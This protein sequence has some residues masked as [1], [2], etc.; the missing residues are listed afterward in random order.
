MPF[1]EIQALKD[2]LNA[3][4]RDAV[5]A[6]KEKLSSLIA[7]SEWDSTETFFREYSE[8]F[9]GETSVLGI[10]ASDFRSFVDA[11]M[12][13]EEFED[14]MTLNRLQSYFWFQNVEDTEYKKG[15]IA[16]KL[17]VFG[18]HMV[19]LINLQDARSCYRRAN[20]REDAAR[21]QRMLSQEVRQFELGPPTTIPDNSSIAAQINGMITRALEEWQSEDAGAKMSAL[22]ADF[23]GIR[24]TPYDPNQSR[25]SDIFSSGL[26]EELGVI[27]TIGIST[28]DGRVDTGRMASTPER[29]HYESTDVM[30]R[31]FLRAFVD[32]VKA[33]LKI[34]EGEFRVY[35]TVGGSLY[36]YLDWDDNST[37]VFMEGL[38]AWLSGHPQAALAFWI[39]A[40]E[41]SLRKRLADLGED[42]ISPQDRPGIENFVLFDGLLGKAS[43]H[44]DESTVLFWR[45]IYST[46]NGLGWN[47]RN[48]YCHGLLPIQ[49]MRNEV[50]VLAIFQSF[51]FLLHPTSVEESSPIG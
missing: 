20:R 16:E 33:W 12:P 10:V 21:I 1:P 6:V 17:S 27:R 7:A 22:A 13:S 3:N 14:V 45:I 5:R 41:E 38:T 40:F 36:Q 30:L 26:L 2:N 51:L 50:F 46:N 8:A 34:P 42:I 19:R 4:R 43:R 37:E 35:Q 32:P 48:L 44:F 28:G 25:S 31:S 49:A 24:P 11:L 9:R 18:Q 29:I 39:P 23:A 47:L 15:I